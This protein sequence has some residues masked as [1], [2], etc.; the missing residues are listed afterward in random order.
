MFKLV[1][2]F[3]ALYLILSAV[4]GSVSALGWSSFVLLFCEMVLALF[5]N[6]ILE[7]YWVE[8][9]NGL[10]QRQ[11]IY[12]HFGTFSKSLQT[13]MGMLL[14][15]W[16]TVTRLLTTHVSEWFMLF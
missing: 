8:P 7:P 3:D 1:Q 6:M 11:K 5:F 12:D 9:A 14:G 4:R 15:H 16:Y 10:E 2:A 13:M